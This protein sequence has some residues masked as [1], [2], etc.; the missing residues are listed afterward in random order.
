MSTT[1]NSSI[2][3]NNIN[4]IF[5]FNTDDYMALHS[6]PNRLYPINQNNNIFNLNKYRL[7]D[8]VHDKF[9]IGKEDYEKINN[10]LCS[11]SNNENVFMNLLMEISNKIMNVNSSINLSLNLIENAYEELLQ[12]NIKITDFEDSFKIDEI[13]ENLYN[14][15][16]FEYLD[17][18]IFKMEF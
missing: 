5:N 13:E 2:N 6:L 7:I 12:I 16:S 15:Y 8:S 14:N 10:F 17:R 1:Y 18:I 3:Y 9:N 4:N 11:S